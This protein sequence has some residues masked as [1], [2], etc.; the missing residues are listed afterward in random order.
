MSS[1]LSRF[2]K[3]FKKKRNGCWE[4]QKGKNSEGYGS[5]RFLGE[6]STPASRASWRLYVGEIPENMCVL[7]KCDNPAC[8][9]PEHL[10]L[11]T[12]SDNSIDMLSKNRWPRDKAL[13]GEEHPLS[14]ATEDAV[15]AIRRL[16]KDTTL[17]QTDIGNMYGLEQTTVSGIVTGRT[18]KQLPLTAPHPDRNIKCKSEA[19]I[20]TVMH[21][22]RLG[23]TTRQIA[24]KTPISKQ[25][26]WRIIK[27]NS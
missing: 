5:F 23:L 16:W 18:W 3:C 22:H 26:V 7:H 1:D 13:L 2:E 20:N 12:R 24:K 11:G 8:V 19:Y 4:W 10:F 17:S 9:R 27:A 6:N 21:Y 15:V 25:T 14:V